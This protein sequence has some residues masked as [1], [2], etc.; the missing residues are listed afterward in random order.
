M[1]ARARRRFWN[2]NVSARD[3]SVLADALPQCPSI[4]AVYIDWNPLPKAAEVDTPAIT[5]GDSKEGDGAPA[6]EKGAEEEEGEG[7]QAAPS[8][9]PAAVYVHVQLLFRLGGWEGLAPRATT[10]PPPLV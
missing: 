8:A 1:V 9:P 4:K 3:L 5:G 7:K 6:E 2:A 10:L